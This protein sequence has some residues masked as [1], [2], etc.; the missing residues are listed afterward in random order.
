MK[1]MRWAV[2]RAS[3]PGEVVLDPFGGS[4]TT[5]RACKDLGRRCILIEQEE[6]YCEIAVRRLQQE[7]FDLAEAV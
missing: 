2:T 6:R 1:W 5:A 7:V 4:G 3:R